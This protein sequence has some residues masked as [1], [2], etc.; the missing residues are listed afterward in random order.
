MADGKGGHRC[1]C[2]PH[3]HPHP[4]PAGAVG[5]GR[6]VQQ[7]GY[8]HPQGGRDGLQLVQVWVGYVPLPVRHR[9]PGDVQLLCQL[10]LGK[11]LGHPKFLEISA[12]GHGAP[13]F[14]V[15]SI[16]DR[17]RKVTQ[18]VIAEGERAPSRSRDTVPVGR[19]AA[20]ARPAGE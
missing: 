12:D 10:V 11:A 3:R 4:L 2:Q 1:R 6:A 9:L 18:R 13:S 15:F 8:L 20:Y 19:G 16:A 5:L 14:P 17:A 7:G